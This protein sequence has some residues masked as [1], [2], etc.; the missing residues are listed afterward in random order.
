MVLVVAMLAS[1]PS[2]GAAVEARQSKS[3]LACLDF[4]AAMLPDIYHMTRCQLKK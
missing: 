3:K 1:A 2:Y 4:A